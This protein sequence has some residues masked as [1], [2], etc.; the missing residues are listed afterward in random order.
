MGW[1]ASLVAIF[2]FLWGS[3]GVVDAGAGFLVAS[4]EGG[5]GDVGGV[6]CVGLDVGHR[7]DYGGEHHVPVLGGVFVDADFHRLQHVNHCGQFQKGCLES[8]GDGA[9]LV[10]A[11]AQLECYNML[12]HLR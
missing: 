6:L 9:T 1:V 12:N 5:C 4:E 3:E 10:S 2:G 11:A 7:G 8:L